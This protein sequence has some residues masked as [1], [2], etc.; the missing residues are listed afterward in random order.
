[1]IDLLS[2]D[3][4]SIKKHKNPFKQEQD[5]L[6]TVEMEEMVAKELGTG[7]C[8]ISIIIPDIRKVIAPVI[9]TTFDLKEPECSDNL[10]TDLSSSDGL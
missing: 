10:K 1:M 7:I 4:Y 2:V 6:N 3:Q 5:S 9:D 8:G